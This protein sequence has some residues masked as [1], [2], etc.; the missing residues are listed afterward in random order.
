MSDELIAKLVARGGGAFGLWKAA[1]DHVTQLTAER[2][3]AVA[4]LRAFITWM[5]DSRTSDHAANPGRYM[6][7]CALLERAEDLAR[8]ILAKHPADKAEGG[9]S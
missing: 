4:A 2:D 6:A 7:H 1:V 3:E 8:V 5:D 9:A